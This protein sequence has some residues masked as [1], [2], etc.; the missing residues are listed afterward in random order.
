Y[1]ENYEKLFKRGVVATRYCDLDAL[2]ALHIE[3]NVR[4][5]FSNVGWGDFLTKKYPTYKRIALEFLSSLKAIVEPGYHDVITFRLYN[6]EHTWT[7]AKLN[8]VLNLPTG[9]PRLASKFWKDDGL[10][11]MLTGKNKYDSSAS[12]SALVRH[13]ALRYVLRVLANTIFGREDNNK[14]YAKPIDVGA[15]LIRQMKSIA[16]KQ[17]TKGAIVVG[18]LITPIALYL[19]H[20]ENLV[21]DG[22]IEGSDSIDIAACSS[23]GWLHKREGTT[24][25]CLGNDDE[26][27]L[28]PPEMMT[29][30]VKDNW[31][32]HG[33]RPHAQA[34]L[35]PEPPASSSPLEGARVSPM[36]IEQALTKLQKSVDEIKVEQK[37]IKDHLTFISKTLANF[38]VWLQSQ[39]FPHPPPLPPQ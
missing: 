31:S 34:P 4:W 18:G 5:F 24:L 17:T 3:D 23:M 6:V 16:N 26:G 28:H 29:L 8:E 10:W 15:F 32:F 27:E 7:L 14:L 21:Q 13:P 19:G 25:W 9:G 2:K 38:G 30:R 12:P 37:E 39:G 35:L 36:F 11:G 20:K 33:I 1:K 22:L